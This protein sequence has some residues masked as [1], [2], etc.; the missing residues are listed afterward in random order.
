MRNLRLGEWLPEAMTPLF[1]EL[2]PWDRHPGNRLSMAQRVDYLLGG[3]QWLN[4]LVQLGFTVVLLATTGR[5]ALRPLLGV[6]VLLPATLLTSGLVRA[7][8]ALPRSTG[9]G[10]R[11]A[12]LAFA[13]WL[14]LSWTV[15]L[16]CIQ[17]LVRSRGVFLRTP[18]GSRLLNALWAARGRDPAGR[19]ALGG[20][21]AAGQLPAPRPAAVGPA[22]LAGHGLRLGAVHGLDE[23]ACQAVGAAG[24]SPPHRAAARACRPGRALRR[25][26]R[27]PGGGGR[28]GV[29]AALILAGGSQPTARQPS[30]FT[31]P[32]RSQGGS[33]HAGMVRPAMATTRPPATTSP[34]RPP[35]PRPPPGR[36]P[37]PRPPQPPRRDAI[38]LSSVV[39][40]DVPMLPTARQ[41]AGHGC[42]RAARP[43]RRQ[44]NIGSSFDRR[45]PPGAETTITRIG[46][47][48]AEDV[49][50]AVTSGTPRLPERPR[51][52]PGRLHHHRADH[53]HLQ[54]SPLAASLLLRASGGE[55]KEWPLP[56]SYVRSS[57]MLFRV[58]VE[59]IRRSRAGPTGARTAA[60]VAARRSG[61]E[62]R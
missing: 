59:P 41:A 28:G 61:L 12:L 50:M 54:P 22:R 26:G 56:I 52:G 19:D 49:L 32:H 20:G 45:T 17:G 27:G 4:D 53:H 7:L 60:A 34:P 62:G 8:W 3:L 29:L 48:L 35:T 38:R 6:A 43:Q 21:H 9:I 46:R 2:W 39:V 55:R 37:P 30:P 14:S 58:K 57:A 5:L 36:P 15:A 18:N 16:A 24:A 11:R 10:S 40:P 33:P 23:P 13:N 42:R 31:L 44:C 1:A 51:A 47:V 25:R